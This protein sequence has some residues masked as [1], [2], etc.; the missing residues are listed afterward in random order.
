MNNQ[1]L[2]HE[3]RLKLMLKERDEAAQQTACYP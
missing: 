2:N 3:P 1:V